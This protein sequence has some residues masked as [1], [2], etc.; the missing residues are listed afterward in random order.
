MN[1]R[2][3]RGKN[4]TEV[5][6]MDKNGKELPTGLRMALARDPKAM[7]Y[8]ASLSPMQQERVITQIHTIGSKQE[9]RHFVDSMRNADSG[10]IETL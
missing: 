10:R 4:N 8:F 7:R 6:S 2:R 3:R 9:M 5:K 1:I